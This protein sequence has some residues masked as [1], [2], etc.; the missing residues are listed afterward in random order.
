MTNDTIRYF[1]CW[2]IVLL[3]CNNQY[4]NGE[5]VWNQLQDHAKTS[6]YTKKYQNTATN[7]KNSKDGNEIKNY[8][9]LFADEQMN[10]NMKNTPPVN[11]PIEK[12]IFGQMSNTTLSTTN[13][14]GMMMMT[15]S[16]SKSPITK[17]INATSAP[18]P[19][20]IPKI[21]G[22]GGGRM[23][24][25]KSNM[26]QFVPTV[27]PST[28]IFPSLTLEPSIS[29]NVT[30]KGMMMLMYDKNK[31]TSSPISSPSTSY[32]P[33]IIS[34]YP[35]IQGKMKGMS[36]SKDKK[37]TPSPSTSYEPTISL[38]PT[39][40]DDISKGM[41]TSKMTTFSPTT[42]YEPTQSVYPTIEGKMKGMSKVRDDKVPSRPSPSPSM[43]SNEPSVSL[44]PTFNN[45]NDK[46]KTMSKSK[47]DKIASTA[48]PSSSTYE[49]TIISLYPTIEINEKG[50]G[51]SKSKEQ[52]ISPSTT[53]VPTTTYVP[54]LLPNG[55]MMMGSDG[56]GM[57]DGDEMMMGKGMGMMSK[58]IQS[59]SPTTPISIPKSM[60]MKKDMDHNDDN[61]MNM[62]K[63]SPKPTSPPSSSSETIVPT[64]PPNA[65]PT[66]TINFSLNYTI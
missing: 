44:Y 10:D 35:T 8:P 59:P 42:S 9:L 38:Y 43:Y 18:A 36:I 15:M 53:S 14:K 60:N 20:T 30:G 54:S 64:S 52:T 56:M 34:F 25:S 1:I 17:S 33:T 47:D 51:M 37:T 28:T 63:M 32:E 62:S 65:L 4:V 13:R 55:M 19:S 31:K 21:N 41:S 66:G 27:S 23:M 49:P 45:D 6:S 57:G 11:A 2:C 5:S 48:S 58:G 26:K 40:A 24:M 12:K 29:Y 39:S 3:S 46:G 16:T 61:K 50:M 22:Q 7:S